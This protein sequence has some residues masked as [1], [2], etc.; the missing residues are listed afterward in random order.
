MTG[1]FCEFVED[2]DELHTD[3]LII[4]DNEMEDQLYIAVICSSCVTV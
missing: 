1:T 2:Q 4:K 3:E